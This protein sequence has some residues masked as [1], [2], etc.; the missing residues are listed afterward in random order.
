MCTSIKITFTTLLVLLIPCEEI[1]VIT[2]LF[3]GGLTFQ[4]CST[5]TAKQNSTCATNLGEIEIFVWT[6]DDKLV[7]FD[8]NSQIRVLE[9]DKYDEAV[10]L[11]A[12]CK[13]FTDSKDDRR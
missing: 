3:Q 12:H 5:S 7:T 9:A 6:M 13:E 8:S 2:T 11:N 1:A 10:K 4:G